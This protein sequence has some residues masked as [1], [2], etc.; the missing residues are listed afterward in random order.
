MTGV[1]TI[2]SFIKNQADRK[3]D[4]RLSF[5]IWWSVQ[6]SEGHLVDALANRGDEG[7]DMLRKAAGSCK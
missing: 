6:V 4:F 5:K 1:M 7:R 2:Q 3:T